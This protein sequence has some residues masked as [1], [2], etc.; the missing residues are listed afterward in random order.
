MGADM[1]DLYPKLQA[2]LFDE[3]QRRAPKGSIGAAME[4][5]EGSSIGAAME[6]IADYFASATRAFSEDLRRWAK[7]S[8][9]DVERGK[10]TLEHRPEE[11]A[12][13][14]SGCLEKFDEARAILSS[15][16]RM[17]DLGE[18]LSKMGDLDLRP[19]VSE[20]RDRLTEL[21]DSIEAARGAVSGWATLAQEA[22]EVAE[23][24]GVLPAPFYAAPVQKPDELDRARDKA[25]EALEESARQVARFEGSLSA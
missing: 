11:S 8:G 18:T 6:A 7:L 25:E 3:E 9:R 14:L 4:T 15:A 12:A 10:A 19:D 20:L 23:A 24:A 1:S 2:S 21:G 17:L 5:I 13:V 22:R 16:G